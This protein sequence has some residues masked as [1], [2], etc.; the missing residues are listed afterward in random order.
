MNVPLFLLIILFVLMAVLGGERGVKSFF[1]LIIN[2]VVLFILVI[3]MH[4]NMDPIK[5]TVIGCIII[6]YIT[7]F[8]INGFNAK[9]VSALISVTLVVLLTMLLTYKLGNDA[10][11]Q[12]FGNEQVEGLELISGSIKLNFAK[13]FIC[14]VLIGLLGA[15]I[16]VAISISSSMNE[17]YKSDVSV[18]ENDLFKSGMNIGKDVLGTM[19]NTLLFAFVSGFMTFLIFFHNANYPIVEI[20]NTKVFCSEVFQIVCSGIGII[21]II[22]ITAFVTSKVLHSKFNF[23]I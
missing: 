1:T 20:I 6:S 11:I 18:T 2:F 13:I 7:L 4:F 22:P 15:I 21:L 5:V 16:D 10:K 3:L 19:T 9:T 14:Q 17:I 23:D 12:G 8:Y